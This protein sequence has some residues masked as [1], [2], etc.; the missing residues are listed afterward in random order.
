MAGYG[1]PMSTMGGAG[2]WPSQ[3]RSA[4]VP[5]LFGWRGG[6]PSNIRAEQGWLGFHVNYSQQ[7]RMWLVERT[8]TPTPPCFFEVLGTN[9]IYELWCIASGDSYRTGNSTSGIT[10]PDLRL[11]PQESTED[12]TSL[13]ASLDFIPLR[14]SSAFVPRPSSPY[15]T[16]CNPS[17]PPQ[18]CLTLCRWPRRGFRP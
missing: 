18:G 15:T 6:G 3:Q 12:A 16:W 11:S 4:A 2:P 13:P 1:R 14:R 9:S 7:K 5:R 8:A 10:A 17:I